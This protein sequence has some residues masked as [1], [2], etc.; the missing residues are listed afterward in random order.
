MCD[1]TITTSRVCCMAGGQNSLFSIVL[2]VILK[3]YNF[4]D[5]SCCYK[6]LPLSG[7]EHPVFG[8]YPSLPAISIQV[9][10]F[11]ASFQESEA[12]C[13]IFFLSIPA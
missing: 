3:C 11:L 9:E 5:C 12:C 2:G 8:T 13:L 6:C 1:P 4:A 10:A 7:G